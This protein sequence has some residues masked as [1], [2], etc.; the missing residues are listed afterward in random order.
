MSGFVRVK[1]YKALIRLLYRNGCPNLSL[2]SMK[3]FVLVAKGV[4]QGFESC[5]LALMRR[6][7]YLVG[8][9]CKPM[10][11]LMTFNPRKKCNGL[12][13]FNADSSF[14]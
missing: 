11:P 8:L 10:E 7:S 5:I 4:E 3:S 2:S 1:Y 9:K 14:N 13:L 12:R 6:S